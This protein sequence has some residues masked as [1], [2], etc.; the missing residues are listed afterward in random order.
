[1]RNRESI[2]H[3]LKDVSLV[4]P[5]VGVEQAQL[6]PSCM[7]Q[8]SL[9][10]LPDRLSTKKRRTGK[11]DE[12]CILGVRLGHRLRVALGPGVCPVGQDRVYTL[13][14]IR[15]VLCSE[16]CYARRVIATGNDL[17]RY[18]PTGGRQRHERCRDD[19]EVCSMAWHRGPPVEAGRREGRLPDNYRLYTQTAVRSPR[20]PPT[21]RGLFGGCQSASPPSSLITLRDGV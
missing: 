12:D 21:D 15:P 20:P 14:D 3:E 5:I 11:S 9:H 6:R 16:R 1:M 7:R 10:V 8:H 17:R 4:V 18:A 19:E 2:L 13:V